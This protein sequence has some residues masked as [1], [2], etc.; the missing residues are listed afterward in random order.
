MLAEITQAEIRPAVID[1]TADGEDGGS[2]SAG[3]YIIPARLFERGEV[4]ATGVGKGAIATEGAASGCAKDGVMRGRVYEL[5]GRFMEDGLCGEYS[6][7]KTFRGIAQLVYTDPGGGLL[8]I[9]IAECHAEQDGND[10]SYVKTLG[11]HLHVEILQDNLIY[12]VFSWLNLCKFACSM[13]NFNT[14]I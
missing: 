8:A 2:D 13:Q 3:F 11:P 14:L 1:L 6:G 12:F 9:G 10:I 4:Q 7:F 5:E